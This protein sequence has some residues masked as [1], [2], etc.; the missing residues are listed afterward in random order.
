MAKDSNLAV[1]KDSNLA[2]AKDS[3]LAV[4]K[5]SNLHLETNNNLTAGE[6]TGVHCLTMRVAAPI[7][8]K[9]YSIGNR[10]HGSIMRVAALLVTFVTFVTYYICNYRSPSDFLSVKYS[11]NP[12]L[13]HL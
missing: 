13:S 9:G 8:N 1:A 12:P 11:S 10:M 3:N 6:V 5:D 4:A 2:V 7:G